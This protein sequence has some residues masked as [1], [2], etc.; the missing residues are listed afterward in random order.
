[1]KKQRNYIL[2]LLTAVILSACASL[3]PA[4]RY[5]KEHESKEFKGWKDQNKK[6]NKAEKSKPKEHTKNRHT[7]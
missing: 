5:A 1:M 4:Q 3:T 6:M 2:I 7:W